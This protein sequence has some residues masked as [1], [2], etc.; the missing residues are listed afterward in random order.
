MVIAVGRWTFLCEGK[1]ME[2]WKDRVGQPKDKYID[3]NRD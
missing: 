1:Q 2:G 3:D